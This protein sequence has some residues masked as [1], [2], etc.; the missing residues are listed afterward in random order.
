MKHL[1]SF[2]ATGV[3]GSGT[4]LGLSHRRADR[5]GANGAITAKSATASVLLFRVSLPESLMDKRTVE[6]A[7]PEPQAAR[8]GRVMIID[9]EASLVRLVQ[10]L[11]G[12]EHDVTGFEEARVALEALTGGAEFDVV[13]CDLMMPEMSGMEL[14]DEIAK[15]AP[16]LL[17]RFV[18]L[19]GGAFTSTARQFLERIPNR[20][21]DKPFDSRTLRTTVRELLGKV[22]P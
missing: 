19:T 2:C 10:R 8:R 5:G 12:S 3:S 16:S 13:L 9:D 11:L 15:R 22:A 7:D 17:P 18:F 6:P 20:S 21:L 1:E 14:Y 4:G